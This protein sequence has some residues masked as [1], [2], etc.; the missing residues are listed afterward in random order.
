MVLRRLVPRLVY[1]TPPLSVQR[2]TRTVPTL[3]LWLGF[4]TEPTLNAVGCAIEL[5]TLK[6]P[7]SGK[8]SCRQGLSN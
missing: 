4:C 6:G 7:Y 5:G 3:L 8:V 2:V 1:S